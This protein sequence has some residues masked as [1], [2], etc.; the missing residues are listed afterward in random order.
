MNRRLLRQTRVLF[1]LIERSAVPASPRLT[2]FEISAVIAS[3]CSACDI[4]NATAERVRERCALRTSCSLLSNLILIVWLIAARQRSNQSVERDAA[5]A[6]HR[7][8]KSAAA[9]AQRVA[10][11]RQKPLSDRILDRQFLFRLGLLDAFRFAAARVRVP[12]V[13]FDLPGRG[14]RR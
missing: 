8:V 3:T 10:Q 12:V 5:L 14:G 7:Q 1:G 13:E 4:F 11:A 9:V 2:A 6:K